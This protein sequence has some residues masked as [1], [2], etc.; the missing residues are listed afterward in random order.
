MYYRQMG[1]RTDPVPPAGPRLLADVVALAS[2]PER[3]T[4]TPGEAAAADYVARRMEELGLA[5]NVQG[6]STRPYFAAAWAL[7]SALC[8]LACGLALVWPLAGVGLALL[9]AVSHHGD[10]T[11]RFYLVR[12]LLPRRG[13]RHVVGRLA[14]AGA[15][16]RRVVVAAHLDTGKMGRALEPARAEA[17]ARLWKRLGMQPPLLALVFWMMPACAAA[18]GA[19]AVL[20]S[21]TATTVVLVALGVA[22]L[23]PCAIFADIERARPCPGA[24]DNASGVA[25]TL[26]LARRLRLA[27]LRSTE[28][29]FVGVGAEECF[30]HGMVRFMEAWRDRLDPRST[31][32]LVPD[33]VGTGTPR[34]VAGE[35]VAWVHRFDP[36]LCALARE[37]AGG[38][39]SI[40]L[41]MGGTDATA[42]SVRGYPATTIVYMNE[43][44]YVPNYHAPGDTVDNVSEVTMD[45]AAGIFE[46]LVRALDERA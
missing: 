20:G 1:E 45:E 6:F 25:V 9:A 21:G 30:M 31:F 35:G 44:D 33:S 28:V 36:A 32:V 10:T 17:T 40:V 11:T 38:A 15:S 43:N 41:R 8:A 16:T 22:N 29:L 23:I 42:A 13:S 3:G 27:P 4:A 14:P 18:A 7:H 19:R 12:A 34:V 39:P 26:E 37:A 24:N 46:R 2:I 5:P